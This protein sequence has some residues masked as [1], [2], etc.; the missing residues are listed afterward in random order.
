M[1]SD[2]TQLEADALI[3]MEKRK[4]DDNESI[5]PGLGGGITVPLVSADKREN[6]LLDVSRSRIDLKK[7]SYQ[8]R[9]RRVIVIVRLC[10]GGRPHTNP[11]GAVIESN[12]LHTYKAGYGDK[13]AHP[14]DPSDFSDL[15]DLW[16]TLMDFC[17]YCNV[18]ELPN[19][20]R[21]LFS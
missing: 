10:F 13:W 3:A 5:Y 6:F 11:D 16:Q 7:G 2:L 4:V 14:A 18:V 20:K 8:N 21:D 1:N 17:G 9:A 15:N 19:L 12:H